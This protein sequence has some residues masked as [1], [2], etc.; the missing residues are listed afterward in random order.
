M[1]VSQLERFGYATVLGHLTAKTAQQRLDQTLETGA[2]GS[3]ARNV[4]P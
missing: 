4:S 2:F 3:E 1:I